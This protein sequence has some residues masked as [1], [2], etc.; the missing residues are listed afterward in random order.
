LL[1]HFWNALW[2]FSAAVLVLG[3]LYSATV[4]KTADG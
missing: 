2:L 4:L 1:E 3:I